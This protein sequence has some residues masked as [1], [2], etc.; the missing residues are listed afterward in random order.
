MEL[1]N[2]LDTILEDM[3]PDEVLF[4]FLSMML[5]YSIVFQSQDKEKLSDMVYFFSSLIKPFTWH[6]LTVYSVPEEYHTFLESESPY[7]AGKEK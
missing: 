2:G 4:I 6:H 7:I 5:E 3:G 1:R